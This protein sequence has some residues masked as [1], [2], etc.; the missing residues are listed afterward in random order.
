MNRE[1]K[2]RAWDGLLMHHVSYDSNEKIF[3]RHTGLKDKNGKGIFEGDIVEFPLE[4]DEI[5]TREVVFRNGYFGINRG[6]KIAP[7]LLY[8]YASSEMQVIG[9]I[10]E[11]PELL[12]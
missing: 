12:K 11:N 6:E 5:V 4:K 2:F 1:I 8:P 3:Q 7:A 10:F 9:N